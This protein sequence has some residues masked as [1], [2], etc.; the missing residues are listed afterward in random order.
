MNREELLKSIKIK[1]KQS[2]KDFLDKS[3]TRVYF[4]ID[5][6][7]I[8]ELTEYLFMDIGARFNIASG[9]DTRFNIEIIYHFTIERL[10]LIISIRVKLDR[11]KPK[12]DSITPLIKGAEW[13][14]REIHELIG[15]D[16]TGHPN[17]K[18]LL[19]SDDW[20]EGVYPLR[21]DYKEW[22]KGAIRDRG[23]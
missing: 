13:I 20:P 18:R 21:A 23:V 3:E 8:K 10:N 9:I 12:V 11:D 17:L 1:F 6:K 2:I 5:P 7:D 19:L 16:F 15:V 22:D 4:E 14:E